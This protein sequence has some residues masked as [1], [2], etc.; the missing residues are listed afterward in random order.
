MHESNRAATRIIQNITRRCGGRWSLIPI[1]IQIE[2]GMQPQQIKSESHR[3]MQ[4]QN[5]D[6][7]VAAQELP[8][9]Q[10]P[11]RRQVLRAI[12]LRDWNSVFFI[13]GQ[14]AVPAATTATFSAPKP[15][16]CEKKAKIQFCDEQHHGPRCSRQAPKPACVRDLL[17]PPPPLLP[18]LLPL[19]P[20]TPRR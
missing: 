8:Q 12:E 19:Q 15:A 11:G 9:L 13:T 1:Y 16:R 14:G 5:T 20:Q 2:H 7:A 18:E 17:L 10:R 3:E 4:K 6:L